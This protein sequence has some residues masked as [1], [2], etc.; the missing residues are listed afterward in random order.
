MGDGGEALVVEAR[1]LLGAVTQPE[2]WRLVRGGG[3]G[4]AIELPQRRRIAARIYN[5]AEGE[6][7]A[8]A[9]RVI[10][11]L[12]AEVDRLRAALVRAEARA[13]NIAECV[14][15]DLGFQEPGL[16]LSKV[17][18]AVGIVLAGVGIDADE[19]AVEARLALEPVRSGPVAVGGS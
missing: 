12:A 1:R 8:A 6:L 5:E 4:C 3:D 7:L 9:P 14:R 16:S 13:V 18:M 19:I 10:E 17:M 2:L 11:A 15:T